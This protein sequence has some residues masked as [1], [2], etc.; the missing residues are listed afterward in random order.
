MISLV[1]C[2]IPISKQRNLGKFREKKENHLNKKK[3]KRDKNL[4]SSL[5]LRG[6]DFSASW[7]L[8]GGMQID[9]I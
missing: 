5:S 1:V 4:L 2:R 7:E 9:N 6:T 8:C 3:L